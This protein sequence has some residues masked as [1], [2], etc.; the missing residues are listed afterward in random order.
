MDV[1]YLLSR[2]KRKVS[3]VFFGWWIV[4][5][6]FIIAIYTGGAIFYGFTAIFE[7]IAD[8]MGWGYA[9][10]ALGA[11]IRGLETGL[12]S[13]LMGF[14]VD[15]WGPRRLI[16]S[17][18]II[19]CMGLLLLSRTTSLATFYGAS[20]L[21]AVGTSCCDLTVLMTTVVRWFRHRAGIASGIAICGYALGGML[22][23]VITKLTDMY[24]WRMAM[25]II[26]GG[27]LVVV[28]PLSF[29]FRKNPEKYGSAAVGTVEAPVKSDR[30][31]NP[32]STAQVDIG[33]RQALK[34]SS[35]WR[36]AVAY[37]C[38][39]VLIAT[40]ITHIM[41]YFSSIGIMRSR[42]SLIVTTL[43]LMS[44]G[45]RLGLGGLAD[46]F[47]KRWVSVTAFALMGL[48]MVFFAFS[49]TANI[50]LLVPF[51]ILFGIGY[52]GSNVLR[53]PLGRAYFGMGS[54]G[55]IFG[56]T[57]GIS[58]I[59]AVAGPPLAGWVYDK[60]GTYQGVWFV[61][62]GLSLIAILSIATLPPSKKHG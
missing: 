26:A 33:T 34:S 4:G 36:I 61:F 18:G 50:W 46:R 16:F 3:Q 20:V 10:V 32:P 2:L 56:L 42:S 37:L 58:R 55:T 57:L 19:G 9:Q 21:I 1:Y 59:G 51:I 27:F 39:V 44:I 41:P 28:L 25:V 22:V 47:D 8:E 60:W 13:P 24:E 29:V 12:L 5:A 7:P 38:H 48:G 45:G 30:L 54:F 53:G 52:G 40:T 15:R 43:P 35:F 14:L 23:P 62:I 17:G 6:S 49:S 31:Y 11:S